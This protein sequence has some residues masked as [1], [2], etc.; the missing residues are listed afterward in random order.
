MTPDGY[1]DRLC[2][3]L[4]SQGP[5]VKDHCVG[6]GGHVGDTSTADAADTDARTRRLE[7]AEQVSTSIRAASPPGACTRDDNIMRD[8]LINNIIRRT[9]IP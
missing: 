4:N 8:H 6:S 5:P 7:V 3:V 1:L 2:D 9:L